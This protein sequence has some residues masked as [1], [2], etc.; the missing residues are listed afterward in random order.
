[1]LLVTEGKL[2]VHTRSTSR[3]G[4]MQRVLTLVLLLVERLIRIARVLEASTTLKELCRY[5]LLR[6]SPIYLPS[7]A[8]VVINAPAVSLTNSLQA[9]MKRYATEARLGHAPTD[10]DMARIHNGGPNG[11]KNPATVAYWQRVQKYL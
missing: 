2:S 7:T 5:K 9:Y 3:I 6:V 11:Y 4:R 10:E 8:C 1:M